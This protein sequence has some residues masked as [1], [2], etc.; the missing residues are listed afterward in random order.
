[1]LEVRPTT[2]EGTVRAPPSKSHTHRA[3]LL[4]FLS[5]NGVIRGGLE[6]DDTQATLDGIQSLG[7]LVTREAAGIRVGGTLRGGKKPV[8]ARASGTTLR[9]LTGTASLLS[10]PTKL[11]A[12]GSLRTRP[13]EPLLEALR[14][15]GV[16][17]ESDEGHAPVTV[18]GPLRGGAAQV[19]GALSSQFL[20]SLLLACPLASEDTRLELAGP[21]VS[22]PYVDITLSLLRHHGVKVVEHGLEFLVPARQRVRQKPYEVPGD[23]SGAAFHLAAAAV[24]GGHV[25][26]TNL[27]PD[28]AQGDRA[29]LDHLR[30]F[31]CRV[32]RTGSSV[33]VEGGPLQAVELDVGSTPDLFPILCAVAACA[34]GTTT[35]RGAPHLRTKESDRIRAMRENL[36]R[37]GIHAEEE[38]DGVR[39]HGGAPKGAPIQS[40]NDHRVAMAMTVLALRAE[41]ASTLADPDVVNKSYPDFLRDLAH[42]ASEVRLA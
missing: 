30:A 3:F 24:T 25:A 12:Q 36:G 34:R 21:L 40:F 20:S 35:L 13:M 39:V 28:D 10:Q 32:T 29:I 7:G 33:A 9:L 27:P 5:G 37:F 22:R 2:V 14:Q 26:V 16:R 15:L 1:M 6:S 42:I 11:E 4:A 18:A 19:H 17:A 38:L 8:D 23:Y 41:G 31:G